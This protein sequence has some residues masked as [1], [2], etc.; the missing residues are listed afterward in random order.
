MDIEKI[1]IG[2]IF[3]LGGLIGNVWSR[4]AM[5]KKNKGADYSTTKII[6]SSWG[7]IGVGTVLIILG[8]INTD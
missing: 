6:Y 5:E 2:L 1:I 7:L 8:I 4:S 3:T